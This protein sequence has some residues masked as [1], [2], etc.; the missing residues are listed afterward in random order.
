MPPPARESPVN[1]T[2]EPHG[3]K[4]DFHIG[5]ESGELKEPGL[6]FT[7]LGSAALENKHKCS[8]WSEGGQ[9]GRGGWMLEGVRR[10][11]MPEGIKKKKKKIIH[12][13]DE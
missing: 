5:C 2:C 12:E 4:Q 7:L 13:K 9:K 3:K 1:T 8:W 10:E 6:G 11:K